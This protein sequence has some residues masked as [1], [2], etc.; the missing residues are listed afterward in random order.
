MLD[1]TLGE[2]EP[3]KVEEKYVKPQYDWRFENS[4]NTGR[5]KI[6]LDDEF[7]YSQWRTNSALSAHLDCI[8]FVNEVNLHPNISDQMHYDYLFGSIKKAKRFGKKKTAEEKKEEKR[9]EEELEDLQL[10][11][12]HYKYNMTKAKLAYK[13]LTKDQLETIKRIHQK[14]G[15][16]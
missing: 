8:M 15:I 14:G 12:N 11:Q 10:I 1:V 6:L 13:I 3:E 9:L 2:R 4:I 5:E 7:K 16:K